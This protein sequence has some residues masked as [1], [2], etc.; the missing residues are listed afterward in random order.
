MVI[1]N[2]FFLAAF[3]NRKFG[4]STSKKVT[5]WESE[6]NNYLDRDEADNQTCYDRL[7]ANISVGKTSYRFDLL[8]LDCAP[9]ELLADNS[10]L[11]PLNDKKCKG[12]DRT[13]Y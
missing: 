2:S 10:L 5:G 9:C 4:L 12:V 8:A 3:E 6:K 11:E 7:S 1:V 13:M